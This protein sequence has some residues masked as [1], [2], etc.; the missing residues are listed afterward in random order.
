MTSRSFTFRNTAVAIHKNVVA[1]EHDAL[2]KLP[3]KKRK[4]RPDVFVVSRPLKKS[5]IDTAMNT[6]RTATDTAN[7]NSL[8]I[9]GE[10]VL[11]CIVRDL[12]KQLSI[13]PPSANR[14]KT[15]LARKMF[16]RKKLGLTKLQFSPVWIL[17][18]NKYNVAMQFQRSSSSDCSTMGLS[19]M[20]HI[21][22]QQANASTQMNHCAPKTLN[23]KEEKKR[24]SPLNPWSNLYYTGGTRI[25]PYEFGE[26]DYIGAMMQ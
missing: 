23:K 24:I 7:K 10:S 2:R 9:R 12:D 1:K 11:Q 4:I 17:A 6:S 3:M 26:W 15:L 16:W 13:I 14:K 19:N 8:G 22:S 20:C 25:L 18:R 21:K 5:R